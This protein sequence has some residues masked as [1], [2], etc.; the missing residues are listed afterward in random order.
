[1]IPFP[2]FLTV[3]GGEGSAVR[4]QELPELPAGAA[5]ALGCAGRIRALIPAGL[6]LAT[7]V[8]WFD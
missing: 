4:E 5:G 1:M 7:A 3:T 6:L 2:R 8:V